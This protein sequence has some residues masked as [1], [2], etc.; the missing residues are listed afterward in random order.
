M[1]DRITDEY[2]NE[3][4]KDFIDDDKIWAQIN[5]AKNPKASEIREIIKKSLTKARL[6]PEET[7]K[8]INVEDEEL[9]S[10]MFTA[11]RKLKEDIYGKR[12]V[13]F[14]PLYVANK[15]GNNCIYCGFRRD[16]KEITR[17]TLTMEEL[18]KEVEILENAGHKRLILVYGEHPDYDADFIAKTMKEVYSVKA[19]RGVIRRVNIN[20]APLDVE[21]YKTL[22]KAGIGTFQIFQETYHHETYKKLHPKGDRKSNYDWRLYGLDRAMEGGIDD[23]GIGALIGLYDWRFEV[24]GL[25]YHAIHLEETFNGVGPHTISFPRIESALGTPFTLNPEYKVSDKDFKKL[26]AI[27]RLSVPYTGMILTARETPEV[28]KEIIQVGISQIDA[29]SRV[30]VGGYEQYEHGSIP[31]KEQFQLGDMRSLD[32]VIREICEL[33]CIPSFCTADY[34]CGRTGEVFMGIAKPGKIHNFCMPNAMLTFK[35]YLLDYASNLTREIGNKTIQQHKLELTPERQKI[36]DERLERI[37]NGERD[38]YI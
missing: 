30:G 21:G 25:L 7:A 13:F 10:E 22:K 6:E 27:I 32:E 19:G 29:G 34:R 8:L 14:A 36:V 37:E 12:I 4:F 38:I 2:L 16:N 24:M 17:K 20:A 15:C 35:E 28:R 9:L 26:V 33:G 18:H 1:L 31:E 3:N 23:L 11:A 5:N